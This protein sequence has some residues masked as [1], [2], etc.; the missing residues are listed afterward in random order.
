[1]LAKQL[2]IQNAYLPCYHISGSSEGAIHDMLQ[3]KKL[4][5]SL[6]YCGWFHCSVCKIARQSERVAIDC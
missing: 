5:N 1:M 3:I 6:I 2:N 4:K